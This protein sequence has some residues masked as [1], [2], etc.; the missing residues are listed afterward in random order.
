MKFTAELIAGHKG[1]TAVVVPFDPEIV[2]GTE[3]VALDARREGWLV[4]GTVNGVKFDGWIG[5][6]W[7]RFFIIVEPELAEQAGAEVGEMIEV[8]VQPTTGAKALAKAKEQAKLTTAPKRR[9]R[10]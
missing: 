6:R 10:R 1:V 9:S 4:R 2:W 7:K 3:P 5:Y 8:A